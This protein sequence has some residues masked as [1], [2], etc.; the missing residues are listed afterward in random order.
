MRS[1]FIWLSCIRCFALS[2]AR[3]N[4]WPKKLSSRTCQLVTIDPVHFLR[5]KKLNTH[6]LL[7]TW[8][9]YLPF[10]KKPRLQDLVGC[11]QR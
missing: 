4:T 9:R 11:R 10:L 2:S 7:H 3:Q 8:N 6:L 1:N 5:N